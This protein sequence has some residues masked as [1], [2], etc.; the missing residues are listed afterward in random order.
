MSQEKSD[1]IGGTISKTLL[2]SLYAEEAWVVDREVRKR[3]LI[4]FHIAVGNGS[5][6]ADPFMIIFKSLI[7]FH[8]K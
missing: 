3:F 1:K 6:V 8:E 4:D 7:C 2:H 5:F